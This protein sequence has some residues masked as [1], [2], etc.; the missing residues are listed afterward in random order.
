MSNSPTGSVSAASL[1]ERRPSVTIPEK[2]MAKDRIMRELRE[3]K[4]NDFDWKGGRVPS[5]TYYL[6]EDTLGVQRDAYAEYIGENG[7]GAGRAFKSLEIMTNDIKAMTKS[8]FHAPAEAGASFT[9]GGTESIFMALKTARDFARHVRGEPRGHYQVVACE[10]A[11]ACLEKAGQLLDV[12]IVRTPYTSQFRADPDLMR[13]AI[14]ART[15]ML[16]ASAANFPFGTFDPIT[17]LGALA[18]EK[19]LWLHVDGC[20]SGFVSPFAER[21]GYPIPLWDFR[22]PGVTSLSADIH[23]FGYAAK[24]ASVVIYRSAELQKFEAFSFSGWPRGTYAT[25][26]FMGTKAGGAVASAWAVMHYLGM[27]GYMRAARETM[28]ATGRLIAGLNA[29]PEIECLTPSGE[30]NIVTFVAKD[31]AFDIYAVAD[32]LEAKGWFRGRMRQPKGIQQGVNPAHL[33]VVDEYLAAV[34]EAIAFV[35]GKAISGTA[36]DERSY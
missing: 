21:L 22:V 31:P 30:S 26:T 18:Q 10:T 20:W 12:E 25:P 4:Q 8:L 6:D 24:G 15:I 1:S 32:R 2:G 27:D 13:E 17:K 28:E 3:L 11:H 19:Q 16:F 23:K 14:N 9:S 7:L 5:Y 33:P 34:R 35:K 29:I 36:Y